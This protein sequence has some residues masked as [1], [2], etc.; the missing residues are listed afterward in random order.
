MSQNSGTH[1]SRTS[2]KII[3][4]EIIFSRVKCIKNDGVGWVFAV[5]CEV[6]TKG[7]FNKVIFERIP[8]KS[9]GLY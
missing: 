8:E 3:V 2:N 7:Y 4:R 6:V 1:C 9:E 5:L